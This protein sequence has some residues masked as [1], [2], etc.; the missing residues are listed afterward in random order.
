MSALHFSFLSPAPVPWGKCF[1][2]V[3]Q[4][5]FNNNRAHTIFLAEHYNISKS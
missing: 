5:V 4:M 1:K 2:N 3:F